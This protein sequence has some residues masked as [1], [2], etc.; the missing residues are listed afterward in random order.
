MFH[1]MKFKPVGKAFHLTDKLPCKAGY[2]S[3]FLFKAVNFGK[4]CRGGNYSRKLESD[5]IPVCRGEVSG[6]S[7]ESSRLNSDLL[8]SATEGHDSIVS[9]RG[10]QEI[11]L[12]MLSSGKTV[13]SPLL[14]CASSHMLYT[15]NT[16]K[17]VLMIAILYAGLA[18]ISIYGC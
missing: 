11:L 9:G 3:V 12:L 5:W 15:L 16:Y 18:D 13:S 10:C 17:S 14:S 8:T 7:Q 1:H 6:V 4:M 2:G